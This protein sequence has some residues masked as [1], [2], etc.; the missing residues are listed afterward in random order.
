MA[1][2]P[3]E[4]EVRSMLALLLGLALEDV[5]ATA[6]RPSLEAWDSLRHLQLV[7]ALEEKFRIRF[8][9]AELAA[10]DSVPR[11]VDAIRRKGP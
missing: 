11:L 8:G 2:D 4:L 1:P 6:S 7:L 3:T 5:A 10:L 9:D